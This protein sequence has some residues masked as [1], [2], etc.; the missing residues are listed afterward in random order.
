MVPV[1]PII[2]G[3]TFVSKFHIRSMYTVRSSYIIIIIIIIITLSLRQ[4]WPE[5]SR[6]EVL[7]LRQGG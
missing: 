3:I 4:I 1:A 2:T 5:F 7:S 6:L